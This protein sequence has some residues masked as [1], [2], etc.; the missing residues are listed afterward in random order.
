MN[1]PMLTIFLP[2]K[3]LFLKKSCDFMSLT[4]LDTQEKIADA[5]PRKAGG[6]L[7]ISYLNYFCFIEGNLAA[8][9]GPYGVL[10]WHGGI[11]SGRSFSEN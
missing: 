11:Y 10:S 7:F 1:A 2:I 5:F 6:L 4:F 8:F 9:D 3:Y